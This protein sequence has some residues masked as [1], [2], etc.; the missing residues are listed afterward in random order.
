ML[1]LHSAS[2]QNQLSLN[3]FDKN[4]S[5]IQNGPTLTQYLE[6]FRK[7]QSFV[8]IQHY[9]KNTKVSNFMCLEDTLL[10]LNE[11]LWKALSLPPS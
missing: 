3:V 11:G 4:M 10:Y 1:I 9:H 7:S 6:G 2:F 5:P 8:Y